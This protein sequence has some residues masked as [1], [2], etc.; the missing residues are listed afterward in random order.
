MKQCLEVEQTS[1]KFEKE[2]NADESSIIMDKFI[3]LYVDRDLIP[4]RI[5]LWNSLKKGV[6]TKCQP[7]SQITSLDVFSDKALFLYDEREKRLGQT[8]WQEIVS[9][10]NNLEPWEENIDFLIFDDSFGWFVAI[11]HEDLLTL[12]AGTLISNR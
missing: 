4:R 5:L 9:F 2:F 11:T 10:I 1:M 6:Q 8:S 3:S 12:S 7:F